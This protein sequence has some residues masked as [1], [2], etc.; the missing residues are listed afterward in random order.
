MIL[1]IPSRFFV[2]P[3]LK[4]NYRS[5]YTYT[6]YSSGKTIVIVFTENHGSMYG[7]TFRANYCPAG[8]AVGAPGKHAA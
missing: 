2:Q 1:K 4:H 7:R 3:L 5:L 8:R 6:E